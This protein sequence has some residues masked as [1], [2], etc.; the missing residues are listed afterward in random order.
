MFTRQPNKESKPAA[1]HKE[2][3]KKPRAACKPGEGKDAKKKPAIRKEAA[4]NTCKSE[5]KTA[6]MGF[7][8]SII[9][10]LYHWLVFKTPELTMGQALFLIV[11]T[12]VIVCMIFVGLTAF[13][14][15]CL[16]SM[17]SALG[18][19]IVNE[20]IAWQMATQEM[21]SEKLSTQNVP[22]GPLVRWIKWAFY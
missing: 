19:K 9:S 7:M 16:I 8:S 11:C 15:G 5:G 14:F 21:V 4:K 17:I 13:S 2:A 10:F 22:D 3:T 6:K 12:V 1:G 20:T 18:E